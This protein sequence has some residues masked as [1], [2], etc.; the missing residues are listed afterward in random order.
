MLSVDQAI[1]AVL[2]HAHPLPARS[3]PLIDALGLTLAEDVRAD[4]DLPPFDKALMDGYAVRS[5][6]LANPGERS[7]RVVEEVTAGRMPSRPISKGEA[8]RIMTGAPLPHGADA[9]VIVEHSRLDGPNVILPGPVMAGQHR[10]TRGREMKAGELLLKKGTKIDATKLG[11]IASAGYT[12]VLAISRP[13]IAVVPTGDE[14]VPVSQRPEAGQIRNTN[15]LMLTGL[16]RAWGPSQVHECPVAPDDPEKLRKALSSELWMKEDRDRP[17]ESIPGL[18]DVLIVSGGVSAGTKDLV[19]A[20]LVDL[21]VEPVFHKVNVKPGK[22]LWFG[23]GPRRA[24]K[25]GILVFGLP[26]NPVSSVVSFLLF[27]RP[28]LEALAGRSPRRTQL[29]SFELGA[30]YQQRGDRPTYHPARLEDGRVFPLDWA[31]SADLRT[32][33]LADG[34]AV[35]P[36]GDREFSAGEEV[37]FLPLD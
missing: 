18:I 13:T 10:L 12:E 31:G 3:T 5:A 22:P 8:S 36:A 14:L 23:V 30:A 21:G 7:L 29:A 11:L 35:F 27:V 26:G 34:F 9:V 6:D 28:A 4:I 37:S 1:E 16:V 17:A 32:A 33:A 20:A 15:G 19:P 24:Y 2:R 25:P